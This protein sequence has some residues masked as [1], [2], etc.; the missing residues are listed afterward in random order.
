MKNSVWDERAVEFLSS[1]WAAGKSASLIAKELGVSRNA[2]I[3]K[4]QRLELKSRHTRLSLLRGRPALKVK[5]RRERI[6]YYKARKASI[7]KKIGALVQS[8]EVAP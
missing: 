7:Q 4:V 8:I 3:G 5:S 1:A 6:E 2:I